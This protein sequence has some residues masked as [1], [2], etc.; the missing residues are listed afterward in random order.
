MNG[1][2][3]QRI[4]EEV[5]KKKKSRHAKDVEC[6]LPD[7]LFCCFFFFEICL[8][9]LL[10]MLVVCRDQEVF[11]WAKSVLKLEDCFL[12]WSHDV[13]GLFIPLCSG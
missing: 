6:V 8:D 4:E 5:L 1:G 2:L 10:K 13:S 7:F 12:Y 11:G 9:L 3:N